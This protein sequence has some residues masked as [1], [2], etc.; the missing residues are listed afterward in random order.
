MEPEEQPVNWAKI[1]L[2]YNFWMT[3]NDGQ[4]AINDQ[5]L[6]LLI[7]IHDYGTL[8]EAAKILNISYRKAWG[9]LKAT[10]KMLGIPLIKKYRG[11]NKGGQTTLTADG[12]TLIQAY[13]V[14]LVEFQEAVTDI[15][16]KF[17]TT[18]I[19]K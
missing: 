10:E 2:F 13:K 12:K 15:I 14:F 8:R 11:G 19:N 6:A 18:L 3:T 5:R 7:A 17:K 9:D 1:H 16:K 4:T